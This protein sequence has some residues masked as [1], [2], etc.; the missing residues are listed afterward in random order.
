MVFD[1]NL[2]K[3]NRRKLF[4]AGLLLFLLFVLLNKCSTASK[5]TALQAM[6]KAVSAV[7][8][9]GTIEQVDETI[10]TVNALR[11]FLK[12]FKLISA[13]KEAT[14]WLASDELGHDRLFI[15]PTLAEQ[16]LE[17]KLKDLGWEEEAHSQFKGVSVHIFKKEA[18]R[19]AWMTYGNLLVAAQAQFLVEEALLVMKKE[20]EGIRSDQSFR[21]VLQREQATGQLYINFQNFYA[22]TAKEKALN[23][24]AFT[25]ARIVRRSENEFEGSILPEEGNPFFEAIADQEMGTGA[26]S[27]ILPANLPRFTSVNLTN[28]TA[29]FKHMNPE[30]PDWFMEWFLPWIDGE[31]A[32]G[33]LPAMDAEGNPEQFWAIEFKDSL[34]VEQSLQMFLEQ[35]GQL[36]DFNSKAFAVDQVMED[37][38]FQAL[39]GDSEVKLDNPYFTILEN[40]VIFCSSWTS[41]ELWLDHYL[42]NNTLGNDPAFISLQKSA[43]PSSAFVYL[44]PDFNKELTEPLSRFY[45]DIKEEELAHILIDLSKEGQFRLRL[46]SETEEIAAT[47]LGWRYTLNSNISTP[48]QC[49]RFRNNGGYIIVFQDES[50]FIYALNQSGSLL[51]KKRLDSPVLSDFQMID[52]Y[53]SGEYQILFNTASFV[54][55][56]NEFGEAEGMFPFKLQ[57]LASTGLTTIDFEQNK[58]YSFFIPTQ[59]GHIYGI[60]Q[61]G[62]PISGWNPSIYV[63]RVDEPLQHFQNR[64]EDYILAMTDDNSICL[65]KKNGDYHFSPVQLSKQCIHSP[66]FSEREVVWP[67]SPNTIQYLSLEGKVSGKNIGDIPIDRALNINNENKENWI[68]LSGQTLTCFETEGKSFSEKWSRGLPVKPDQIFEVELP[69][70]NSAAVGMLAKQSEKIYLFDQLGKPYA[71]FPLAGT[72]TFEIVDLYGDGRAVLIVNNRDQ[73]QTYILDL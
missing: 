24:E 30:Q 14:L 46:V 71:G 21:K 37:N 41:M 26:I 11:E 3:L 13:D 59:N 39:L 12:D 48:P 64:G 47:A 67:E 15:D 72:S 5:N 53:D 10:S 34:L 20:A 52:L 4:L 19:V 29:F 55:L 17:R 40:Y 66:F 36:S 23:A 49:I 22:K 68:I 70:E 61:Y 32:W 73:I 33:S 56:L 60:D 8:Y 65:Y 44:N 7:H 63:G 35:S 6:P 31:M 57:S 28:P 54:Y 69:G 1:T 16:E 27:R 25:W 50:D 42:V 51:W 58:A 43:E 9:A 18:Y 2:I 38:L 62:Q 45:P